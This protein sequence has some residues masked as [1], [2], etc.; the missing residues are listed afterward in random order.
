MSFSEGKAPTESDGIIQEQ[1]V[2][3]VLG[4]PKA[5]S[6]SSSSSS[7]GGADKGGDDGRRCRE[8]DLSSFEHDGTRRRA[9]VRREPAWHQQPMNERYRIFISV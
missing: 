9:L 8:R 6:N 2:V 5:A 4:V 7:Y 3:A 1:S